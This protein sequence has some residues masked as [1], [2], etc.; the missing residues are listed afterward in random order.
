MEGITPNWIG[1]GKS[2]ETA[3][4][5][6]PNGRDRFRVAACIDGKCGQEAT[7]SLPI[8]V[9]PY[10]Y[11]TLWFMATAAILSLAMVIALF[12]FRMHQLRTRHTE[13]ERLVAEKT[14]ALKLANEHLSRLPF[15]D[16]LT[17]LANRRRLDEILDAEWRRA[18]R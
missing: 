3:F 1:T 7:A 15:A 9:K 10:F 13:M 2:D 12:R 11:Q 6:L 8:I 18:L 5:R 16:A 17:G 14:E 4:P